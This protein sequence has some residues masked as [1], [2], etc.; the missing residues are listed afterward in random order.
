VEPGKKIN[1]A[2][3][4]RGEFA[5]EAGSDGA[6]QHQSSSSQLRGCVPS[7]AARG[8]RPSCRARLAL[9]DQALPAPPFPG[10][11]QGATQNLFGRALNAVLVPGLHSQQDVA[12]VPCFVLSLFFKCFQQTLPWCCILTA[13][14]SSRRFLCSKHI[15]L[16]FK[17]F[18]HVPGTLCA[19][20][21][22]VAK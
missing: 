3:R 13:P 17:E 6:P 2:F 5:P 22:W 4:L 11:E 7:L 18:P 12:F 21:C 19:M 16:K 15:R 20:A 14:S 10:H 9:L 1:H 8:G